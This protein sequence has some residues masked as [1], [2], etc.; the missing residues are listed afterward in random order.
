MTYNPRTIDSC[1]R[2]G[3]NASYC[4]K[5]ILKLIAKQYIEIC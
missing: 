2:T 5:N 4:D 1:A 3:G